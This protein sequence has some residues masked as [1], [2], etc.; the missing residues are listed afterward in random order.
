MRL[1]TLRQSPSSVPQAEKVRVV[2]GIGRR[3]VNRPRGG[4]EVSRK[5]HE[6]VVVA[7]G[8]WT[9]SPKFSKFG[10]I[11]YTNSTLRTAGAGESKGRRYDVVVTTRSLV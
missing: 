10:S 3:S 11:C 6:P 2:V 9:G 1:P 4:F 7:F 5:A 8:F